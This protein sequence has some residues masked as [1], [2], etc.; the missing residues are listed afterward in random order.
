MPTP[1]VDQLRGLEYDGQVP[2][3]HTWFGGEPALAEFLPDPALRT[4]FITELEP[5]PW[6]M[7]TER[8]PEHPGVATHPAATYD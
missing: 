5:L 1:A 4:R 6:K 8:R 7:F 3:W 2:L